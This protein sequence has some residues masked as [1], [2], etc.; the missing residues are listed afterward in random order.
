MKPMKRA[1][2]AMELMLI[3][4]ATLFMTALFVRNLQPR[5]YEPARTA[6][7]IVAWYSARVQIGLW[8]ML[9]A[10]PLTALVMGCVTLRHCWETDA[11]LRQA[12]QNSVAIIR[13]HVAMLLVAAATLAAGGFLA[14]VGLHVLTD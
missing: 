4:P 7:A 2:A 12:A 5:Q 13:P 1:I 10:L 11:Q 9:I 14:I 8:L 6:Q 3:F